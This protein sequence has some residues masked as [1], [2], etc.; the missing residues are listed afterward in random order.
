METGPRKHRYRLIAV[1]IS[2]L[3]SRCSLETRIMGT[4]GLKDTDWNFSLA[5]MSY[6]IIL[7]SLQWLNINERIKYKVFF[8]TN[9]SLK[10][11]QPFYL[12][13]LFFHSLH[14]VVLGL[15]LLSLLVARPPLTSRLKIANSSFYYAAPV[16]WNCLPSTS[17]RWSSRHSFSML[18]SPV[19]NL[20]NSLFL[21]KLK[22]ISFT[23][24][25]LLSLYSP[26]LSQD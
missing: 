1:G 7:K 3:D 24:L 8:H 16:L 26:I 2:F 15:P 10:T 14:I 22:T 11:G 6:N 17:S 21:N 12:I 23:V 25:F 19:S 9:K 13:S 20:S 4:S 5:V 18:Y